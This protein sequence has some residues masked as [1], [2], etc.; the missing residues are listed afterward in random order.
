MSVKTDPLS[1]SVDVGPDVSRYDLLLA[2]L[3][4]PLLLGALVGEFSAT[5]MHVGLSFGSVPTVLL[6]WYGLFFDAPVEPGE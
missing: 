3:P 5:P 1:D 2:V 6:L 4:F